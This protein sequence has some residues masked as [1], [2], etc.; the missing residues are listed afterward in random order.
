MAI[1]NKKGRKWQETDAKKKTLARRKKKP[2]G[3]KRNALMR[4]ILKWGEKPICKCGFKRRELAAE[5]RAD[6]N[7]QRINKCREYAVVCWQNQTEQYKTRTS[8]WSWYDWVYVLIKSNKTAT[9]H[10]RF[11]QPSRVLC[12]ALW[13]CFLRLFPSLIVYR[14]LKTNTKQ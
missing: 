10:I 8:G 5:K 2:T 12:G 7:L 6:F 13:S 4:C 14:V 3:K 9:R 11:V 1:A